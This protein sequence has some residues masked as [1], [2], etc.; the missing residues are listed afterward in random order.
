M[1]LSVNR[2]ESLY[3]NNSK[4]L[5][6]TNYDNSKRCV[7]KWNQLMLYAIKCN[8]TFVSRAFKIGYTNLI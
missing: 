5:M 6:F 8:I 1:M 2:V 7:T 4:L 3:S